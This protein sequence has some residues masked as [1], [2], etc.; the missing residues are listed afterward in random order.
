MMEVGVAV[1]LELEVSVGRVLPVLTAPATRTLS[2]GVVLEGSGNGSRGT[3]MPDD[4]CLAS[5]SARRAALA[6]AKRS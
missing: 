4:G 3:T 5:L 1:Q 6:A 2:T